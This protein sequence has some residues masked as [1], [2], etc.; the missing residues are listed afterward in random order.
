MKG[1]RPA[2]AFFHIFYFLK[3]H[4]RTHPQIKSIQSLWGEVPPSLNQD[5][6]TRF[7]T[8]QDNTGRDQARLGELLK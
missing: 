2:L 1:W 5:F 6:A 3:N 7:A 8:Q 4:F